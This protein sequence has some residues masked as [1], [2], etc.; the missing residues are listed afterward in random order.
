MPMPGFLAWIFPIAI[1]SFGAGLVSGQDYPSKPIRIVTAEPGGSSDFAAR[2]IAQGLSR[3]FGHKVVVENRGGGSGIIAAQTVAKAP[4]DGYTLLYYG[5]A[6]WLL[7]FL[8]DNVPYD[9]VRDFSP[10]TLPVRSPNILVV[11]PSL[12]VRSVK[13]LIALAKARP[14]ELN[15]GSASRGSAS[16]LAP[17]LFKVMAGVHIVQVS[18][19]GGGPALI[20]LIAGQVQLMFGSATSVAP[21]LRSGR[22]RA[23]A[24][25][26]AQPSALLPD[27]PTIAASGLPGY[28][29]VSIYGMFAPANTSA[30]IINQLNQEIV[31]VLNTPNAKEKFFSVGVETVGSSPEQLA[32]AIKTDMARMGKVI[33]DASIRAD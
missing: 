16:H 26:S 8:Q 6:I 22:L 17:E 3:N 24:I 20:D 19:K 18:Y 21:H 11:H 32:A 4:P 23:L 14:G 12:P 13:E 7:P 10:I 1:I 31:R 5:P 33:K 9:P 15:Y 29:A 25:T 28:E 27:L 30:T 2:V